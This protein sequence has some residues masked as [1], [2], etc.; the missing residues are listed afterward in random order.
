[1]E[2]VRESEFSSRLNHSQM[3]RGCTALHYAVLADSTPTVQALLSAG[4]F[5]TI[6]CS[7]QLDL[8]YFCTSLN[9]N[10]FFV[11]ITFM[12]MTCFLLALDVDVIMSDIS[13]AD[14]TLCNEYR[15]PPSDYARDVGMRKLMQ[16]HTT[17]Y[18][19]KQKEKY[20]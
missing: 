1:M 3:F 9:C 14:P 2:V 8:L 7:I 4:E 17:H 15:L 20:V 16:H 12:S 10:L 19:D 5:N 18:A 11:V 13:G 6:Q